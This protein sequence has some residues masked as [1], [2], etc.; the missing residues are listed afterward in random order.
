MT[1]WVLHTCMQADVERIVRRSAEAGL[2]CDVRIV[3]D[4]ACPEIETEDLVRDLRRDSPRVMSGV[5]QRTGED[6][7]LVRTPR[8]DVAAP[9][10]SPRP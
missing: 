8:P 2:S 3:I 7:R 4:N 5:R 6:T 9:T 10:F 1:H